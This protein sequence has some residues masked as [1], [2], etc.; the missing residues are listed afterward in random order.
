MHLYLKRASDFILQG[1]SHLP[2]I[3]FY[4]PNILSTKLIEVAKILFQSLHS[5]LLAG[6]ELG[7]FIMRVFYCIMLV[8]DDILNHGIVS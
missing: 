3:V 8:L 1:K 5:F 2:K 6:F 7:W 4:T